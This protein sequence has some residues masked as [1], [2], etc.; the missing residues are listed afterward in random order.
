MRKMMTVTY[1]AV[2]YTA[3]F[4]TFLYAIGFAGSM[5]VP[6]SINTGVPGEFWTSLL[7]NVSLLGL[8]A[9]QHTIMARPA[10]KEWWTQYVPKPI[11]RSTFVLFASAILAATFWQW[12]PMPDVIWQVENSVAAAALTTLQMTGWAIVLASSFLINHFDLFGLRQVYLHAKG[13][14]YRPLNFRT[15]GFY[16]YCRHPLMFGFL[17][18]FWVTPVMTVGHLVFAL[19][20]TSY[21]L[22]GIQIEERDLV[23][24]HPERYQAYREQVPMLIPY[25]KPA[26]AGRQEAPADAV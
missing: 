25:R 6:K 24:T 3:F 5:I 16:K 22:L 20:T 11:E 19:T 2:A 8:F 1:G 7:V 15:V 4:V 9:V 21:I 12:R 14:P 26:T 13:E 18:A 10:F 23:R 17:I